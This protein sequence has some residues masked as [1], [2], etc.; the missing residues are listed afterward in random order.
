VIGTG[1]PSG[2]HRAKAKQRTAQRPH[3][4]PPELALGGPGAGHL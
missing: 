2:A 3:L 4:V 1:A